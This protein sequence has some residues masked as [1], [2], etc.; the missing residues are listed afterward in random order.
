MSIYWDNSF[1][2]EEIQVLSAAF[3]RAWTFIEKSGGLEMDAPEF[4]R[5]CLATHVMAIAQAGE[6][7]PT[8]LANG[9]IERYRQQRAQQL[10]AAFRKRTDESAAK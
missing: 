7:D 9:A 1:E 8:R 5:S 2:P 10:A 6:K 3:E 4:C